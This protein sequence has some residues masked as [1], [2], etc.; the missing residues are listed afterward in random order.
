MDYPSISN[1]NLQLYNHAL[2]KMLTF[3]Y[4]IKTKSLLFMFKYMKDIFGIT[5]L[6]V[7]KSGLK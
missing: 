6:H 7:P 3:T 1:Y 2:H 4:K 5:Y